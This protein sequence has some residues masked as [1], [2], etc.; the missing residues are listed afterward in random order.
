MSAMLRDF[1][2]S[3]GAELLKEV[4]MHNVSKILEKDLNEILE[5]SG[6]WR[7]IQWALKCSETS[8][9]V[10]LKENKI[11]INWSDWIQKLE[12]FNH[13]DCQY[14]V[15]DKLLNIELFK[16]W[17]LKKIKYEKTT[18][19]W[20]EIYLNSN[21]QS[22]DYA[23]WKANAIKKILKDL[24]DRKEIVKLESLAE[25]V[26][27]R[28][29]SQKEQFDITLGILLYNNKTNWE[30]LNYL[31]NAR[32]RYIVKKHEEKKNEKNHWQQQKSNRIKKLE[33]EINPLVTNWNQKGKNRGLRVNK[34]QNN[35]LTV[36]ELMALEKKRDVVI[37]V[38][39]KRTLIK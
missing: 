34:D 20:L 39:K 37:I 36:G 32:G 10:M 23:L 19:K 4:W 1:E 7:G 8:G 16:S 13:D 14:E 22:L 33:P 6:S 15:M 38:K 9:G 28:G 26:R 17:T 29:K 31:L 2:S 25:I 5:L 18:L 27:K 21:N 35:E 30:E 24:I 12:M 11:G 3:L